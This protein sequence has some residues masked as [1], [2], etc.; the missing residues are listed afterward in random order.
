MYVYKYIYDIHI[1]YTYTYIYICM[2]GHGALEGMFDGW[3]A[4]GRGRELNW[5]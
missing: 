1:L 2:S 5:I 3:G 4:G